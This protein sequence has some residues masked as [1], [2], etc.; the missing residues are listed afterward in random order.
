MSIITQN[1]TNVDI[2]TPT[3]EEIAEVE[4]QIKKFLESEKKHVVKN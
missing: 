2:P 1:R 3:K 4:R